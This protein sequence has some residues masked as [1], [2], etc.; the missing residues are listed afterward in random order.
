MADDTSAAPAPDP[1]TYDPAIIN[2]MIQQMLQ[3]AALPQ[4]SQ[5]PVERSTVSLLG[6]ALGGGSQYGS[7]AERESAGTRALL[8]LGVGML[9]ASG[10]SPV[11]RTLGEVVAQGIGGAE[12]SLARSGSVAAAQLAAQQDYAKTQQEMQ[13]S[14]LKEVLPLLKMQ[15]GMA[16]PNT[17]IGGAGKPGT[18]IGAVGGD[19]YEGAIGTHEGTGANP[20]SSA[21]GTGQFLAST[22]Q[23]FAAANPDLFKGM[24]PAQVLAARTDPALGT[25]AITWLAQQNA[26]ALTKA[27][28]TPSGPALGIAHYLGAGTA[29]KVLQAPDNAP[30]AGFVSDAAVRA[31]PELRTM[32]VAQLKQRYANTPAPA[33]L[34]GPKP[35][36]APPVVTA[37]ATPPAG[38]PGVAQGDVAHPELAPGPPGSKGGAPIGI[39]AALAPP[40][41]AGTPIPAGRLQSTGKPPGQ[42]AADIIQSGVQLAQATPLVRG[43]GQEAGPSNAVATLA[44]PA[45]PQPGWGTG[46]A[47]GYNTGTT[48]APPA[49]PAPQAPTQ[50]Q[51]PPPVTQPINA[52]APPPAGGLT[53]EQFQQQHP[54]VIPDEERRTWTV[55]PP[56]LTDA[57]A[58]KAEAARQLSLARAGIS[59]DP[60]KSLSDY[61]T[62][63]QNVAKLQQDAQTKSLELQQASMQHA[64]DT[65]RQLYDA[66][67]QRTAAAAEA[68]RQRQAATALETQRGNQAIDLEKVKAGQTWHQKLE[69]Q[70]ATYAQENTI[71]PMAAA[72]QKAHQMNLGLAQM[73]AI[74]PD[75]PPGGGPLGAVLEAHPDLAPLFNSA[76]ILTEKNANA[77]RLI[78]GLVSNISTEMKPAGLGALRE[79]EWDAFKAQLPSMLSTPAGQQK[80]MALLMN[81]NDRISSEHSWMSNYFSR[82]VPDE[83]SPTPGATRSAHNL[84]SDNPNE[85]VQQRMDRELGPIIPRYAGPPSGNGQAQWEASLPPGKPYYKT[86]AQP[87]P[88]HPGQALRDSNGNIK[89]TRTL[90]IRPWQ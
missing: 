26:D 48:T 64:R 61:N 66:E 17:L 40:V 76:G 29:A 37:A 27:G 1:T 49:A 32:T 33:F 77:V 56:D 88:Q 41:V 12:Q 47:A 22:W 60:N 10:Y 87:D 72:A 2:Q 79:Y 24:S 35:G 28:V 68:E 78:N 23:D 55:Q 67:M 84:E 21:L 86:W 4:Q 31:N 44:T 89:T 5:A 46:G 75:L 13:L 15:A 9:G 39:G 62:A 19:T 63:A 74:L 50:A 25:R 3:P 11:R 7:P 30:V 65:Q 38:P 82:K 6:E 45:A 81:M 14:R 51:Q 8:S 36:A 43:T 69:E 59:G 18:S 57:L 34:G 73:Q 71:K 85:S 80:A 58:A 53:F 83:L 52:P 90:E 16:T 20:N 42:A 54:L 70:A